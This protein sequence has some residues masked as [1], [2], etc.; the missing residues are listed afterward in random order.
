[1]MI[2]SP[3]FEEWIYRLYRATTVTVTTKT[4]HI[5]GEE[6]WVQVKTDQG[7]SVGWIAGA[8]KIYQRI[9]RATEKMLVMGNKSVID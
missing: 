3:I 2:I 5:Q 4:D 8:V 6:V 9:V 7:V 1:M